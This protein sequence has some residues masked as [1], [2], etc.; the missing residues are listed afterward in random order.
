[1]IPAAD[2]WGPFRP[3]LEPAERMARL[4]ALRAVVHLTTGRR[5]D[6]LADLLHQAEHEPTALP[7]AAAALNRLASLDRRHVCASYAALIRPPC[8]RSQARG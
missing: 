5:G 4:R 1:M 8:E 2:A 3:D 6:A 7:L